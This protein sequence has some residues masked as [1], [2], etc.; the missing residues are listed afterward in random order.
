ML[1]GAHISTAGG[2]EKAV[3]R[4]VEMG[5]ECMQI[6]ASSP[7]GWAF[8]PITD[9]SAKAFQDK[10][11]AARLGPTLLHAIYLVAIGSPDGDLLAKSVQSLTDHLRTA[12]QLGALG[13]SFHPASHR[14]QGLDRV[15]DQF[16]AA[17]RQVLKDAPGE[18]LF[19]LE[20]SAGMGDH[21]GS[22]F[23]DLGRIIKA[24]KSPRVAVTLDTQHAWAAG[25]DV[26]SKSGLDDMV[27]E[28]DKHIGLKLLRAV[29]ANDSKKERGSAVDRHDNIGEGLIGRAGFLNILKHRA[30]QSVPFYLEVPGFEGGGP[31]KKNVDILKALRREAGAGD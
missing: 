10:A 2:V 24:I 8:K 3:D 13:L 25:Y 6:F 30:F 15:F 26:A 31:D 14:G 7:R 23:E 17:A 5:A 18:A 22:K 20:N 16:I 11:K 19:M 29:H 28:F 12:G 9:A 4:A 27:A 21:I 1:I